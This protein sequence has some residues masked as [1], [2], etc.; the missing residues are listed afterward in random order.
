MPFG[1]NVG[2]PCRVSG[3]LNAKPDIDLPNEFI[4]LSQKC[5]VCRVSFRSRELR[6][7]AFEQIFGSKF[8][9]FADPIGLE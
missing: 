9:Y 4:D 3:G 8:I 7:I 5:R 6:R 2:F 1:E